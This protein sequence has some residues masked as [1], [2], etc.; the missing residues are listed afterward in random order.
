MC[1]FRRRKGSQLDTEENVNDLESCPKI[2]PPGRLNSDEYEICIL[3]GRQT[4][5]P[6]DMY[7]EFRDNYVNGAGQLC[8]KCWKEVYL[9]T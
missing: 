6:K 2:L 5:V 9:D 1:F 3:C 7:V 4:T 8:Y